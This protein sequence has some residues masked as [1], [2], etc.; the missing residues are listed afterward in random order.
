MIDPHAGAQMDPATAPSEPTFDQEAEYLL[1]RAAQQIRWLCERNTVLQMKSD[2]VD[3]LCSIGKPP[4][5]GNSVGPL[6]VEPSFLYRI[7]SLLRIRKEAR[8][9]EQRKAAAAN[10]TPNPTS[11][12]LGY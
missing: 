6:A 1:E 2:T 11:T 10:G 5:Y 7:E 8:E 12:P 4:P 9:A 3:Q